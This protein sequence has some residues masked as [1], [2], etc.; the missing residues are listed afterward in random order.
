MTD[1]TDP[2]DDEQPSLPL[3]DAFA[4][5]EAELAAKERHVERLERELADG[6]LDPDDGPRDTPAADESEPHSHGDWEPATDPLSEAVDAGDPPTGGADPDASEQ[7]NRS[8]PEPVRTASGDG[9]SGGSA[10]EARPTGVPA[11]NES[12]GL[13]AETAT[14]LTG[15]S[16]GSSTD[17]TFVASGRDAEAGSDP[18]PARPD[19]DQGERLGLRVDR[20]ERRDGAAVV[21]ALID[22][23][24]AL[25]EV[26][27]AMLAHYREAGEAIP[28]DAHAAAGGPG[29]RRYAYAR[30]RTLRTAGLIEHAGAGQYRYALPDLVAAAVDEDADGSVADAVSEIEAGAGID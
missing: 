24:D 8:G 22:G 12:F 13:T 14:D 28:V 25:E 7:P 10:D 11:A 27:T 23:I 18:D 20:A 19:P 9:S 26:T 17:E 29:D 4:A 21:N 5:L 3:I 6:Y 1:D 16:L 2:A 30:N 15:G